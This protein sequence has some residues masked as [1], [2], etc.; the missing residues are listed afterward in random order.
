MAGL[1]VPMLSIALCATLL[2]PIPDSV[3]PRLEK[4]RKNRSPPL[5]RAWTVTAGWV[6]RHRTV[7]AA[8]SLFVLAVPI[9][10]VSPFTQSNPQGTA[11]AT[12]APADARAGLDAL[13]ATGI[14]AGVLRLTEM[15][16]PSAPS[17]TLPQS[18]DIVTTAHAP[19]ASG[20]GNIV[21]AWRGA[22]PF[23]T[24]G[25]RPAADRVAPPAAPPPRR[26]AA[27]WIC[28]DCAN[29]SSCVHELLSPRTDTFQ[30]APL[31][32]DWNTCGPAVRCGSGRCSNG[33]TEAGEARAP[34]IALTT[35][36]TWF[37]GAASAGK[38]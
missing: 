25:Q 7:A 34:V 1:L 16:L 30:N 6:V 35:A 33:H 9:A 31:K 20:P 3:G 38:Q 5:G 12:T 21:D 10:P 17:M 14:G 24:T 23:S 8:G 18:R 28:S 13:T 15:H 29:T 36:A 26:A 22:N 37:T 27:I 2:P 11:T 4:P 32:P 19:R